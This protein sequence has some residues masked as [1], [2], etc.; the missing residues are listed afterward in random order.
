[1]STNSVPSPLDEVRKWHAENGDA[2]RE[3]TV[4]ALLDGSDVAT[5]WA[6]KVLAILDYL[7]A[8]IATLDASETALRHA[9]QIN[10]ELAQENNYLSDELAT[11][12]EMNKRLVKESDRSEAARKRYGEALAMIRLH[13]HFA[14]ADLAADAL[15][16]P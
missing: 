13:G 16:E 3:E 12:V 15:D 10:G 8:S 6:A 11:A 4:A 1:M 2:Y 5:H 9:D 7:D 14:E